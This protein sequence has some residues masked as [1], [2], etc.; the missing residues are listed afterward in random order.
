MT[1]TSE[2]DPVRRACMPPALRDLPHAWM[3]VL[4]RARSTGDYDLAR[5][6]DAELRR[7]GVR[8]SYDARPDREE[9]G[10]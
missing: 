6:A 8:V 2:P 3:A 7:L 5:Y 1:T 9:A 10:R 4:E